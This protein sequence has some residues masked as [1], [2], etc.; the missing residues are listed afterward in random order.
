MPKLPVADP[1]D[2]FAA[3]MDDARNSPEPQPTAMSLATVDAQGRPTARIVLLK[4]FDR[5]GFV[6]YTNLESDKAGQLDD[7]PRAGL[8][9][10]W[11]KL[12]RQV[13]IDGPVE[14]IDDQEADDYFATRPRGSQI[15][16]WA[17]R[18]SR[19]LEDRATLAERVERFRTKFEGQKVPRPPFWSG[20]RVIPRTFEFWREREA[21]LH[22][23]W[24][25][26][27]IADGWQW[28]R[29]RLYP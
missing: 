23:R 28:E 16:A 11:K 29:K 13:R 24:Q 9:F 21:R 8:C 4:S 22:D 20:Y 25:F 6:F 10:L 19:P 14:Q 15:G 2:W 12:C 27:R 7:N 5:K 17:S 26:Q 1:L 18:Q 3:W